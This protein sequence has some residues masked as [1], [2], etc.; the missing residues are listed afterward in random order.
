M[1]VAYSTEAW[2]SGAHSKPCQP[3][4]YIR[5]LTVSIARCSAEIVKATAI[6]K[7]T[8]LATILHILQLYANTGNLIPSYNQ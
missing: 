1:R 4:G 8:S 2:C 6:P 5:S 3:V 7:F